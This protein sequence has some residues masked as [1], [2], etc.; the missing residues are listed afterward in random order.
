MARTSAGL[1]CYRVLDGELQV[2][3][4]HPGGP[5]WAKKDD[6]AWTIPKGEPG[7]G[8]DPLDAARREFEEEIGKTIAPRSAFVPLA[9]VR[10]PGGK[11]VQAFAVS[12]DVDP[13]GLCSNTFTLEWPLRSGRQQTFPEIDRAAWFSLP[14]ARRKI[15]QG[16]TPLL[17]ELEAF[18]DRSR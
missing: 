1:L 2:L 4:A 7:P 18:V 17:D 16:Q 10:Q 6:G 8:E 5:L 13:G 15:L 14:V 11:I 3:L 12:T 9:P